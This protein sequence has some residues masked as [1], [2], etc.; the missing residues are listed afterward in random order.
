MVRDKDLLASAKSGPLRRGKRWLIKYLEGGKISRAQGVEA[1]CYDC[2]GMGDQG[3]CDQ[4]SCSLYDFSPFRITVSTK[5]TKKGYQRSNK[6]SV[7]V[8]SS[9]SSATVPETAFKTEV[10]NV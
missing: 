3:H 2:L 8:E 6:G 1:K 9:I 4:E 10:T 5:N 7:S